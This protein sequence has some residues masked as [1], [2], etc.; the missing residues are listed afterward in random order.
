MKKD[1]K[2]F[3]VEC[4]QSATEKEEQLADQKVNSPG[5]NVPVSETKQVVEQEMQ[6]KP[7]SSLLGTN[8]ENAPI[9]TGSWEGEGEKVDHVE[10]VNPT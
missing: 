1:N 4:R 6:E 8:T 5:E 2:A 10:H 9:A 3:A 7:G